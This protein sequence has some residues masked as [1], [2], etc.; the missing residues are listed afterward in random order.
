[1]II[2]KDTNKINGKSYIGQTTDPKKIRLGKGH[3]C[4]YYEGEK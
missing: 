2:Y 3:T 4:R 1:M